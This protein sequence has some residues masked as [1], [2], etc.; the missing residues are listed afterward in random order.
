MPTYNIRGV[1]VDF[2]FEAYDCQLVYMEKVIQS[3]QERC[4]ALLESPTGT[5]KTLCLLCATL[6]WRKSLGGFSTGMSVKSS[7]KEES[8]PDVSLS[9]PVRSNL[10]AIIYTSRTHS[11][12][13]QVIQELKRTRYRPKM[14]VLGS[15]EQLCIHDEV[16]SLRGK[17]QTNSCHSLCRK[18]KCGHHS[19]VAEYMKKNPHIG[20]EPIDIEDLVNVGRRFGPCPYY[21][22]RELH[23]ITDIFFAP[24]NYL[25]D[26]GNRKS[27]KVDWNNSILIF[28]EAHN[29]ESLCAD[30]ASFELPSWLLKACIIEAKHCIDLSVERREE[31]NDKSRNPDNFAILRALLL[32]LEK[33]IAEVPI[34]SKELGFTKPGPYI[35][36][37]LSELNITHET[38]SKLIQIID[39]A[40]VL[41]E[42]DNQHKAA[43]T[44]C[45]L[46][47]IGDILNTIFRDE[48]NAHAKFY[49][50][51]VHEVEASAADGLKGKASR[52]LSWW[53]FNPGI[54]LEAF[55]KLGVGSVILTSGTLS[56]LDSFA[57]ELKLEFPVRLENPHVITPSQIWAGVVPAGPSGCSFNSSY[58]N[59]DS[60][61]Y[62]QELGNAI[63]NFARIVPDGLLVFFP[64]YYILDQCI[65]CWKNMS[66]ANSTTIWER[67]CKHKKP[68][69]E[70]RQSSL[71]PSSIEDYLAKLKDASASGAVFFAVCRGKVSEGL[72]FADHAGRAVV[73]TGMPFATRTDPKV[74][75]KREYLDQGGL[76][77]SKVLTGEEWYNQQASRAVNQAVGRVIRHRHDYGAIIFCDERFAHPYRQS[78][79]SQWIQPHIKCYSK[80]GDVVFTLTQFFRDGRA[81]GSTDLSFIQTKNRGEIEAIQTELLLE[82]SLTQMTPISQDSSIK[83][84]SSLP[85]TTKGNFSSRVKEFLPAN[86]SS[87]T[88]SKNQSL[89]SKCSRDT[90]CNEKN[91]P[92]PARKNM[93]NQAHEV[94]DLTGYSIL[95]E[96]PSKEELLV[97][98]HARKRK[99]VSME[100]VATQQI[101]VFHEHLSRAKKFETNGASSGINSVRLENSPISNSISS[102][103]AQV[104][105]AL[106]HKD[107][108]TPQ[109]SEVEFLRQKN[110]DVQSINVPSG[111]EENRGSDFL[112]QVKEKLSAE[113]YK[114]FVEF[115]KALKSKTMQ[116]S[117]A[118]QSIVS[119]FSGPDRLPLL[120]RFKDYIPAKHH[121]LYEHCVEV[122]GNRH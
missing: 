89:I 8:E 120:K 65:G 49:R 103:H 112:I 40:A 114:K 61:E 90:I 83:T 21:V 9:Q 70:P 34:Q 117:Q 26:P 85:N 15:R 119:L 19:R 69:V 84:S 93:Q 45:R 96:Q 95:D 81:R 71:F 60:I 68:V 105:T 75:L 79:V 110:K 101:E 39:D 6:A 94:I 50:V 4:N 116:T 46:E 17:T 3:L 82:K 18:R 31:S 10:P 104:G 97:P 36:E 54:A 37:L 109:R 47:S 74:R 87:L 2:P 20:D 32:K 25:I 14:V 76:S 106:L 24:Y 111:N 80:F 13:R 29:L 72:D 7:Q 11:Q 91:L 115:L 55:S 22:S 92:M 53:C 59:R 107:N 102:Q 99:L 23:R 16:S 121:S 100:N 86:R 62:K 48:G 44:T 38:V 67:I 12:I 33:R 78:Q 118:L 42:E 1:D 108:G 98:F 58:R 88:L 57:Q 56:P 30:A 66:H 27:L 73:I 122:N 35:Y 63:V 64:S 52:T 43:H 51:H 28:D 41:I 77:H 5:G 113:E